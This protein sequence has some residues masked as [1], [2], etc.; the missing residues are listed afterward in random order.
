MECPKLTEDLR[1]AIAVVPKLGALDLKE[2]AEFLFGDCRISDREEG[3]RVDRV[4]EIRLPPRILDPLGQAQS[5]E[6]YMERR[7]LQLMVERPEGMLVEGFRRCRRVSV[8]ERVT[9]ALIREA[10]HV[11]RPAARGT[12][13][14]ATEE[15]VAME[16][17]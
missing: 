11:I 6:R 17:G 5:V 1:L 12:E 10:V 8:L 2:V 7:Y 3:I 15:S 16:D 14:E 4:L 9:D 13:V